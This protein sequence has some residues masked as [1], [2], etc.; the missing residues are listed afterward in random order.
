M[1][2]QLKRLKPG[3]TPGRDMDFRPA[4][5]TSDHDGGSDGAEAEDAISCR[6]RRHEMAKGWMRARVP[7]VFST[8]T[9]H[10]HKNSRG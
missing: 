1:L 4:H 2:T 3:H 10:H 8:R 6:R 9:D 5:D 7:L